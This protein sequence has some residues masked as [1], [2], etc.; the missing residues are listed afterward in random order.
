MRAHVTPKDVDGSHPPTV[1]VR[2]AEHIGLQ[3]EIALHLQSD[4]RQRNR[5]YR[6]PDTI[7]GPMP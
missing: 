5:I 7:A 6:P 4:P 2:A 1:T 3:D